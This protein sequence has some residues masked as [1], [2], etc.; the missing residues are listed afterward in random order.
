MVWCV[1]FCFLL[2]ESKVSLHK[3]KSIFRPCKLSLSN[4]LSGFESGELNGN[5]I[6]LS[7][8][9]NRNI[10]WARTRPTAITLIVS[11]CYSK[12]SSTDV[13][14]KTVCCRWTVHQSC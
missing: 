2:D 13:P 1:H 4:E 6:L 11:T 7:N 9:G 8:L 12:Q 3:A 10:I 5:D 14:S